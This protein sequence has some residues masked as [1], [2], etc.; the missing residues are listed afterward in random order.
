MMLTVNLSLQV[1]ECADFWAQ[2][3]EET[4]TRLL[5]FPKYWRLFGG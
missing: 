2:F 4:F 3:Y 5:T 1:A